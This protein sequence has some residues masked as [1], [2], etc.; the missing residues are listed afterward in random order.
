M[1]RKSKIVST[2]FEGA[3]SRYRL[4]LNMESVEDA[5]IHKLRELRKTEKIKGFRPGRAPYQVIHRR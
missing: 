5:V 3:S 1:K 2:S 4:A